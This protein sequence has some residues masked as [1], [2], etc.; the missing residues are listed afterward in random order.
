MA[1]ILIEKANR[2][3]EYKVYIETDPNRYRVVSAKNREEAIENAGFRFDNTSLIVTEVLDRKP[4]K[5]SQEKIDGLIFKNA[6]EGFE[7]YSAKLDRHL[8]ALA[9]YHNRKIQT[10]R[11][12]VVPTNGV[13]P[14]AEFMTKVIFII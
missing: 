11:V 13:I 4:G 14:E 7:Y 10:K 1:K 5:I 2:M 9:H 6:E 3:K 8:T 12:V